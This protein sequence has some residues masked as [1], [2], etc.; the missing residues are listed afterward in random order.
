MTLHQRLTESNYSLN[1]SNVFWLNHY[2]DSSDAQ[3]LWG[4]ACLESVVSAN[5]TACTLGECLLPLAQWLFL[6]YVAEQPAT[7]L[8]SIQWLEWNY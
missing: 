4:N 3:A 8:V 5:A 1:T 6:P 7:C 2:A